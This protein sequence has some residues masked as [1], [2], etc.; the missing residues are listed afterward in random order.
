M[1]FVDNLTICTLDSMSIGGLPY[2]SEPAS[3]TWPASNRAI[4]VPF[5]L[6]KPHTIAK[7]F[8]ANGAAVS[9]NI[10]VGVYDEKF[11]RL[12]AA[13]STAQAGT[14]VNQVFDVTDTQIGPGLFYLA[15]ALDN[16][17]GAVLRSS[18]QTQFCRAVGVVQ[19]ASAFVLPATITPAAP[20]SDYVP[21]LGVTFRSGIVVT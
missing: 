12:V 20:A 2:A 15:C 16:T 11:T 9:G 13:G 21:L 4:L 17:T 5:R 10:D 7:V 19:M 6:W 3:A 8:V 1:Q 14:S 18:L